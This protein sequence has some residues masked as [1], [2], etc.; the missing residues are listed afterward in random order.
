MKKIL[1]NILMARPSV[2]LAAILVLCL[3]SVLVS[4]YYI[5]FDSP[6][7]PF[8]VM[9]ENGHMKLAGRVIGDDRGGALLAYHH[10]SE[11]NPSQAVQVVERGPP[12]LNDIDIAFHIEK[13]KAR[14]QQQQQQQQQQ[15]TKGKHKSLLKENMWPSHEKVHKQRKAI[16]P[17]AMQ[18][19]NNPQ[20]E[21]TDWN[22][23]RYIVYLCHSNLT[24]AGWGDRQHGIFSAYLLSLVTNRTFKV[25]M[26]GPCPLYKLYH[27][28]ILNWRVNSTELHGLSSTHLY[29]LNDRK[30]RE[31]MKVINFNEIYPQDVVY[32][33]TNYDYF[34]NLKAN[35]LYRSIFKQ[36]VKGRPRPILFA[37]LWQTIFKMNKRVVRKYSTALNNA[38]PTKKH[39]LVCAHIRFGRNPTIPTDGD[40]R[41]TLST[42]KPL[43]KYLERYSNPD[44]YR[45]FVASD[46]QGFRDKVISMYPNVSLN[47]EGK[48]IHI[49]KWK[50]RSKRENTT[51]SGPPDTCAG[52]EKV[53]AD[54]HV[55]SKCDILLLTYSVFGKAAAYL[56]RSNHDLFLMENGTIKP[57]KLFDDNKFK[58]LRH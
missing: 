55:L 33:T 56:R 7:S 38:W 15:H 9:R 45:L 12:V 52:F 18:I 24:C 16:V 10:G 11:Q 40:I 35:P 5:H 1:I 21:R 58:S 50:D 6:R 26:D 19:Y 13:K 54:Q 37:D 46:W 30:F 41:N 14:Q 27:H 32:L 22:G 42:I 29:A 36:K 3:S 44:R 53:I 39:K 47:I 23:E 51:D 28:R 31:S 43:W 25:E 2:V 8:D 49:D 57:L 20:R 34:Y 17:L 4:F 48:I